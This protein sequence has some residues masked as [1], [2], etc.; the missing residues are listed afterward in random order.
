MKKFDD[1]WSYK[2]PNKI[3]KN[4]LP[5]IYQNKIG[6]KP[7]GK[8]NLLSKYEGLSSSPQYYIRTLVFV[9]KGRNIRIAG[10]C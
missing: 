8:E 1:N 5:N 10:A 9:S 4:I 7:S 3:I 6:R 2:W